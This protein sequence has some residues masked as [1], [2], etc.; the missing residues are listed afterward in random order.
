MKLCF[1]LVTVFSLVV[2]VCLGDG[3][4]K[5]AA[6]DSSY[7]DWSEW[8]ICDSDC[9]FCGTQTRSRLCGPISG[10]AD[11]TCSGDGTESQPCSSSDN[12][13]MAP[14]PSCCPHTYK[15]TVDIPNRRFYCALV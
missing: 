13:C 10:C 6:C 5:R 14:S 7:G 2:D 1:A 3:R 12:I 8:S 15:K 9:G 11:V 4:L